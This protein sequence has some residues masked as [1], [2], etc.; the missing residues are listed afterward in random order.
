MG[1]PLFL[2]NWLYHWIR[3]PDISY[4][5]YNF[6]GAMTAEI[7]ILQ[8]KILNFGTLGVGIENV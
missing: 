7:R 2:E 5:M 3:R 4:S 1:N 8:Q 6:C